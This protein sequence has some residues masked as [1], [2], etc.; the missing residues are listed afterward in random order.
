MHMH[1]ALCLSVCLCW[2]YVGHLQHNPQ[3]P[4]PQLFYHSR[5]TWPC[6]FT[7]SLFTWGRADIQYLALGHILSTP[8][9]AFSRR[10][11][12]LT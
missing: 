7:C 4:A 12:T 5:S 3:R 1:A 11:E 2:V 8:T 9:C 6:G 10:F